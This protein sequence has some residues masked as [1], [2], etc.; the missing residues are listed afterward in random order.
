MRTLLAIS[1]LAASTS[2][3]IGF[4]GLGDDPDEYVRRPKSSDDAG[5][6]ADSSISD[7]GL[8]DS[9]AIDASGGDAGG[10]S[11]VD[12][13]VSEALGELATRLCGAR[14]CGPA[15]GTDACGV[16]RTVQCGTCG[17]SLT[18]DSNGSCG[19][20]AENTADLVAANCGSGSCGDLE[21]TDRCG[22]RR[23]ISCGSTCAG[24]GETCGG[25]NPGTANVCGCTPETA[26]QFCARYGKN[27][28]TFSG[29]DN[30]GVRRTN[31][32]CG[33]CT[34]PQTCAGAGTAGV[35][36]C[37]PTTCAA[38]GKNCGQIPDE[39]GGSLNCGGCSGTGQTCGGG[40]P[41][42]ANVCGCTPES[43]QALCTLEGASCGSITTA[44][45]CGAT[46]TVSSCGTCS[47]TG[48]TG[49][50]APVPNLVVLR[51]GDGV[52]SL[53]SNSHP[54]FLDEYDSTTWVKVRTIALP[55]AT[56]G[57]Q[58]AL[59]VSGVTAT[60]GSLS[61]SVDGRYLTFGGYDA[62][63]GTASVSGTSTTT[64]LRVF[65]RVDAA[66]TVDTST[67]TSSFSST[68]VRAVTSATGAE[69]WAVGGNTGVV[70]MPFGGSGAG[71]I[72]SSTPVTNWRTV[73]I[74]GGQL[75]A[76][77]SSGE[78]RMATIGTGIPTTSGSTPAILPGFPVATGAYN[79][80][81][82]ADLST[83]I[84]GID[85]I[86]TTDE[87]VS[88]GGLLKWTLGANGLWSM[89][90]KVGTNLSLYRGLTGVASG[91]SVTL[92]ATRNSGS[93]S[94]QTGELVSLTDTT[95]YGGTL[96]ATPTVQVPGTVNTVMRG[97]AFAPIP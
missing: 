92:F 76:A 26:V 64:V 4:A 87:S 33:T 32:A 45:R 37:T 69:F 51:V 79:N 82:F 49:P 66:G 7:S 12:A 40:A 61:R 47:G 54:V 21:V 43:D 6:N 28:S 34:L 24:Q 44:D 57:A 25:G 62:V 78:P 73:A 14:V 20:S 11:D 96:V 65:G 17:S 70:Y 56:S 86:Y 74:A 38:Q 50:S 71:T 41:A 27:C 13:C 29:P 59:T 89:T 22:G 81:F 68:G 94:T 60:E 75:Y 42:V 10:G 95:G 63:P 23:T 85:T 93:T 31:V 2:A 8:N 15:S 30:C 58:R 97:V 16:Q 5:T 48:T 19:C 55:T 72:V 67:T 36:G 46:R 18:C 39:C 84:P 53:T 3:C 83:S 52:A 80:V 77:G 9:A 91:T 90:G 88:T 35:C 1:I